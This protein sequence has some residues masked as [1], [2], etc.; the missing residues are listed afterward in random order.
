MITLSEAIKLFRLSND[1]YV[2]MFPKG[3]DIDE[4]YLWLKVATARKHFYMR[5][6]MVHSIL[7]TED[8]DGQQIPA[9]EISGKMK[10]S[11]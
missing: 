6:T 9:L 10:K 2:Y 1:D 7:K 5:K 4:D 3:G 11:R 8:S